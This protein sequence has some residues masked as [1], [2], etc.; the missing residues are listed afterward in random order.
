MAQYLLSVMHNEAETAEMAAMKTNYA[1][2]LY[3][4]PMTFIEIFPVGA[5]VAL[6]SAALVRNPKFLPAKA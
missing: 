1:N 2:P 6:V 5:L 3:R 4:M